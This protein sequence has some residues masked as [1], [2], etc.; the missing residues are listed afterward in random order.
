LTLNKDVKSKVDDAIEFLYE[1]TSA[2]I[3]VLSD[4][5]KSNITFRDF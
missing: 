3:C 1:K 5:S 2:V 4:A